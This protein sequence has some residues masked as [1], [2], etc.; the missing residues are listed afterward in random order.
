MHIVRRTTAPWALAAIVAL[1]LTACGGDGDNVQP[2]PPTPTVTANLC[3]PSAGAQPAVKPDNR[4][5]TPRNKVVVG[6]STGDISAKQ[7]ASQLPR[8]QMIGSQA[9]RLDFKWD[10]VQPSCGDPYDW[11]DLTAKVQDAV[12]HGQWVQ[13][14]FDSP[15]RWA[16]M[17]DCPR[18]PWLCAIDPAYTVAFA[19]FVNAGIHQFAGQ[20][21]ASEILN[22]PN[23]LWGYYGHAE[24][25][26][27][28]VAAVSGNH[29][30]QGDTNIVIQAGGTADIGTS[31]PDGGTNGVEWYTALKAAGLN[32]SVDRIAMHPYTFPS[33]VL[34]NRFNRGWTELHQIQQLF[35]GTPLDIT[36]VGWSTGGGSGP[37]VRVIHPRW[38]D[39]RAVADN[40]QMHHLF[41]VLVN[42]ASLHNKKVV[43]RLFI[44]SLRDTGGDPAD[45]E[46]HFGL[47]TA[48]G[49]PKPARAIVQKMFRQLGTA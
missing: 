27:A 35:P 20:L 17:A 48:K 8:A 2:V 25:Y 14:I 32:K 24:R 42:F 21:L 6:I 13:A 30:Q 29:R 37:P 9:V 36:E 26:A 3:T 23:Q 11:T 45:L 33:S 19:R 12:D 16:V 4:P 43:D 40:V 31:S 7:L 39:N 18:E 15:P 5:A 22:E 1:S 46:S 10:Q 38:S 41:E 44:Y 34:D 47:E 49:Q 28:L